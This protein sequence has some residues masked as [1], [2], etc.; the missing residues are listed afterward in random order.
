M[1]RNKVVEPLGDYKSDYEFWLDL[2]VKMGYGDEFW[3]GSIKECMNYQLENF[4]ITIDELRAHPTGIVYEAK[5]MQYEK[6]SQIFA[7]ASTRI[8]KGAVSSAG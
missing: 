8:D 1:A 3:H 2:A 7:T 4:G 5:P 6:Y